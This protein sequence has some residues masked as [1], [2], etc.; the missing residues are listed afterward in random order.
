MADPD[1]KWLGQEQAQGTKGTGQ[2]EPEEWI[3]NCKRWGHKDA[4]EWHERK[5]K[6]NKLT[7]F[8]A[9]RRLRW[10]PQR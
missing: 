8:T 3:E 2:R 5:K 6:R 10:W 1:R 9:A 7:E 4:S